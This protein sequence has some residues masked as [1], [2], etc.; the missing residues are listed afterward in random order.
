[1]ADEHTTVLFHYISYK[2]ISKTR[3]TKVLELF[4]TFNLI[5]NI[6]FKIVMLLIA[7]R[8]LTT[9][10]LVDFYAYVHFLFDFTPCKVF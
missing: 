9:D 2:V 10:L 6:L 3:N 4:K 5:N 8:V 1:M 7:W